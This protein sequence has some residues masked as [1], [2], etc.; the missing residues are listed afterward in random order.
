MAEKIVIPN[1]PMLTQVPIVLIGSSV[2]GVANFATI[3][4]FGVVCEGPMLYA[5]LKGTHH[6][7]RGG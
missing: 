2:D 4:A 7:T 5:S 6:T 1:Y 3:G